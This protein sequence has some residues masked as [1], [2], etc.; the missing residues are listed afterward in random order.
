MTGCRELLTP[1]V[2]VPRG[3][4]GQRNVS[5]KRSRIKFG[6]ARAALAD[7][8]CEILSCVADGNRA[9]AKMFCLGRR[10]TAFRAQKPTGKLVRWLGA[11]LFRFEESMIVLGLKQAAESTER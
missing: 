3:A 2:L 11:A 4:L 1:Q 10:V 5:V 7:D 9:F 8:Q 6:P